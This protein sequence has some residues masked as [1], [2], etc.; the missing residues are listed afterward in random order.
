MTLLNINVYIK[1]RETDKITN[2]QTNL[3]NKN[4]QT[5]K[6][7]QNYQDKSFL[8]LFN[9]NFFCI[10]DFM[11]TVFRILRETSKYKPRLVSLLNYFFRIRNLKIKSI[12]VSIMI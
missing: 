5:N 8:T 6:I 9:S 4:K 1:I 7:D 11:K 10:F 2:Q 12:L 3:Q